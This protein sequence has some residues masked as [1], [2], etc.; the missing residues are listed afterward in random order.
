MHLR[1][2]IALL[3]IAPCAGFGTVSGPGVGCVDAPAHLVAEETA[4]MGEWYAQFTSCDAVAQ[5]GGCA[6]SAV[7]QAACCATCAVEVPARTTYSGD[8]PKVK[9]GGTCN[10]DSECETDFCEPPRTDANCIN[11]RPSVCG[12]ADYYGMRCP[13][14]TQRHMAGSGH[15]FGLS[16]TSVNA[17][18]T[19]ASH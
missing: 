6:R 18:G 5:V 15:L 16:T 2:I 7:A 11:C 4:K 1:I 12:C 8:P 9:I 10:H 19:H 14:Y 17:R 3:S 13:R